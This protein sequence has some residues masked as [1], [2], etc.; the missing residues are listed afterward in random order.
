MAQQDP[1]LPPTNDGAGSTAAPPAG[2]GVDVALASE[3]VRP[4]KPEV[5]PELLPVVDATV[6]D[7][8][9]ALYPRTGA[10]AWL[11]G[12]LAAIR[13]PAV[14]A[15]YVGYVVVSLV[16]VWLSGQTPTWSDVLQTLYFARLADLWQSHLTIAIA[17]TV[18][19]VGLVMAIFLLAEV[20]HADLKREARIL[21]LR[22]RCERWQEADQL[23]LA[24]HVRLEAIR[25]EARRQAQ[26]AQARAEEAYAAATARAGEPA[27][28]PQ[29]P[30]DDRGLL[31]AAPR[32]VGREAD[33]AWVLDRLR[34]RAVTGITALGGLGGIGKTALAA[35]AVR[36]LHAE[37]LYRDGIAVV[38]C[39]GL[40][41]P[42][43][44]LRRVVARFDPQ[45]KPPRERQPDEAEDVYLAALAGAATTLLNGQDA[46]VVLDNVEPS[47]PAARVVAPLRAAGVAVLLTARQ[48]L[49]AEAVDPKGT[50]MLDLLPLDEAT[51]VF[52]EY[53]GRGAALDLTP[54]ERAAAEAIA[55]DLGRHTLAVKLAAAY[56]RD[57]VRDLAALAGELADPARALALPEDEVPG[58]VQRSF[59][60]SVEALPDEP[61][62]LFAGLAAVA[63][64]EFGRE[65]ALALGRGL[66]LAEPDLALD[67]LVRRALLQATTERSLPEAADRERRVLHPL[68]RALATRAFARWSDDDRANA[69]R[70]LAAWYAGYAN[71]G[72]SAI[73]PARAADEANIIGALEWARGQG[74]DRLEAELCWGLAQYWRDRGK[75]REALPTCRRPSLRP[76]GWRA[77]RASARTASAS[78]TWSA[79]TRKS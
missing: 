76:S 46:L 28:A 29:G 10:R 65:A 40:S 21:D 55:L 50:R 32:F 30:P 24:N 33:L 14:I 36:R 35:E 66:G 26:A 18:L 52:A 34:A 16:T 6:G 20:A 37:G 41:D 3:P 39:V 8:R 78:A 7:A 19:L 72:G 11:R 49:P 31:P 15:T 38:V 42:A 5:P 73:H 22:A 75:T 69:A 77:R 63:T 70:A 59:A 60:A 27:P 25:E 51:D 61:R 48:T 56:A 43:E 9:Y 58:G 44:V 71:R 74:E 1:A 79:R 13:L 47:L 62:R 53:Y 4:P 54:A 57:A 2:S 12:K 23:W 17:V 64:N 68:L 45:R 67:L